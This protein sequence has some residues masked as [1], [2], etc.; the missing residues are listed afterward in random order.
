VAPA[1]LQAVSPHCALVY[2][3]E[4]PPGISF[5]VLG[6]VF[7]VVTGGEAMYADMGHFG[8]LPIRLGWFAVVLPALLLNY[9]GQGALPLS[10]PQ[11]I[12]NPFY[13]LAPGW[14]HYPIVVFATIATIIASQAIISG[15]YSLTQQAMQLGFLPHMRVLHT[16]SQEK[17]PN[18]TKW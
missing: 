14:L 12:E 1:I 3:V 18:I 2:L 4:T 5:S 6:A 15:A 9:F 10:D 7:L 8:R 11:T 16:A 17:R 13:L